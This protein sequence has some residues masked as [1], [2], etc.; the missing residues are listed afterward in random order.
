MNA[1]DSKDYTA[2]ILASD[3]GH[4]EIA[5]FLVVGGEGGGTGGSS[6]VYIGG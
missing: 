1:K 2:L 3:N 4:T 6:G 5:K